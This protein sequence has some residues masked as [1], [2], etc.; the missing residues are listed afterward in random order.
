[1]CV[2]KALQLGLSVFALNTLV[3]NTE[4]VGRS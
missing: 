4:S 3:K 2:E 1:M